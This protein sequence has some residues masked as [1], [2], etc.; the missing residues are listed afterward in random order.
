VDRDRRFQVSVLAVLLGLFGLLYFAGY[1]IY[2]RSSRATEGTHRMQCAAHLRQIGQAALLYANAQR[3]GRYPQA[4]ADLFS[5][6][7]LDPAALL[8]SHEED[9]LPRSTR[10]QQIA[11]AVANSSYTYAGASLTD[12]RPAGYVIAFERPGLH[13]ADSTSSGLIIPAGGNVLINDGT[14]EYV[15]DDVLRALAV[16]HA[17][18]ERPLRLPK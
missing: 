10:P 18:G 9:R 7:E 6:A 15:G 12:R 11:W 17:R 16:A 5:A 1:L 3:D 2:E 13:A 4:T 14:V 8:C